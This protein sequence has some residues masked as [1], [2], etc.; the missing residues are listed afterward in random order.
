MTDYSRI[1]DFSSKDSLTTGD[2]AK[3]IKGSEVD[4][5]FDELVSVTATKVD[6]PSGPA[7]GDV[8]VYSGGAW[9]AS[10]A[11]VVPIGITTDYA[12]AS[13]PDN[14]LW[15]D[16]SSLSTTSYSALFAAIGYTFG[17]SGANFSLPDARGR[18]TFGTDNMDN[19]VGT[20]GGDAARLTS[21]SAAAVDGDTLGATGG[22]EEHQLTVSEL[23][24]HTH[25]IGLSNE[26]PPDGTGTGVGA[27]DNNSSGGTSSNRAFS[28]GGD[29]AHTNIPPAIV[30]NKIIYAG[31]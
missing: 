15:C 17:G 10:T 28:T 21:G 19:A 20:G 5:E 31:A 27:A 2:P 26:T 22:V 9:T 18:A 25:D 7:E 24:A 6:K 29:A 8:M 12:G 4:A 13:L 23:A 16:G 1:Y 11:G 14:W 30:L 3:L